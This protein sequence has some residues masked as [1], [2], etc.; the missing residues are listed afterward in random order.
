MS[1]FLT[2]NSNILSGI[3]FLKIQRLTEFSLPGGKLISSWASTSVWQRKCFIGDVSLICL[4]VMFCVCFSVRKSYAIACLASSYVCA[5]GYVL[6]SQLTEEYQSS[7]K[8]E[9]K[10]MFISSCL[11]N[12]NSEIW[13]EISVPIAL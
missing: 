13:T 9:S 2:Y 3:V 1:E 4:S 5:Y 7:E 12:V 11:I 8:T 6:R 10:R